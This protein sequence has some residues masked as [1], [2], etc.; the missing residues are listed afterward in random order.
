MFQVSTPYTLYK[1]DKYNCILLDTKY[2][3]ISNVH[4]CR[5]HH[6]SNGG[7]FGYQ[8]KIVTKLLS[9]INTTSAQE[10]S[11]MTKR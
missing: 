1:N 9:A 11:S 4:L 2:D 6:I 5:I 3:M 7:I 8:Y 10:L